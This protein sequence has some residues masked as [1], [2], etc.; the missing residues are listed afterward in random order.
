MA[1][2][3]KKMHKKPAGGFAKLPIKAFLWRSGFLR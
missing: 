3:L 2:A 1:Q